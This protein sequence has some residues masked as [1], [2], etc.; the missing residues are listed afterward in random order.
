MENNDSKWFLFGSSSSKK[1]KKKE[2]HIYLN[3]RFKFIV[4]KALTILMQSD[5]ICCKTIYQFK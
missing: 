4:S 5:I 2:Y 3:T 1:S